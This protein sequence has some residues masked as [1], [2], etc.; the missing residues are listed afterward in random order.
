M[1]NQE[2]F[3]GLVDQCDKIAKLIKRTIWEISEKQISPMLD[4]ALKDLAR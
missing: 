2:D 1:K 3:R 4:E